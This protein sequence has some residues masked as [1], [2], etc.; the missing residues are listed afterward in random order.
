MPTAP[1]YDEP[2]GSRHLTDRLGA[3]AGVLCAIHCAATIPVAGLMSAD[4]G[5][6]FGHEAEWFF[7]S[8]AG[9]FVL[10]SSVHGYRHHRSWAI[11]VAFAASFAIWVVGTVFAT[12]SVEVA[13]HVAAAVGLATTHLVS[14]RRLKSCDH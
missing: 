10:L 6:V 8:V 2:T 4:L 13:L 5:A 11:L 12:G 14:L 9:I 7:V 3:I 1:R